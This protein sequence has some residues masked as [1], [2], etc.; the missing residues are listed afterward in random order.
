[1]KSP[2]VIFSLT[3]F[4]ILP[5]NLYLQEFL[6][7]SRPDSTEGQMGLRAEKIITEAYSRLGIEI[8]FIDLP[9]KRT[10]YEL[11]FGNT[12]GE[13]SRISGLEETFEN[14]IMVPYPIQYKEVVVYAKREDIQ[15][16]TW[17]TAPNYRA[18]IVRGFFFAENKMQGKEYESVN[19][20]TIALS[21]LHVGRLDIIIDLRAS[22]FKV[23]ELG[24][25]EIHIIEPPL[26][27]FPLFHYLNKKHIDLVEPLMRVLTEMENEGFMDNLK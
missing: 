18:G 8:K 1:M 20:M 14:I 17:D 21:M 5:S 13:L 15:N 9:I 26:D 4:L 6:E 24:F 7:L 25:D 3:L 22:L 2:L 16:V 10:M 27:R 19:D 12:D 11:N 23:N